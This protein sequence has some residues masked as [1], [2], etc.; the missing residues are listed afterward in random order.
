V[1]PYAY[2]IDRIRVVD[3]GKIQPHRTRPEFCLS[4]L[5][6]PLPIIEITLHVLRFP[7]PFFRFS[8]GSVPLC[9]RKKLKILLPS[10]LKL[11]GLI[12]AYLREAESTTCNLLISVIDSLLDATLCFIPL[13]FDL[14][15]T[16]R[17]PSSRP[18]LSSL[19]PLSTFG[20]NLD[21]RTIDAWQRWRK[22][23]ST[24]TR[25]M[26]SKTR[27]PRSHPHKMMTLNRITRARR[28]RRQHS[29]TTYGSSPIL[30]WVIESFWYV[31][32]L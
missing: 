9:S 22:H 32:F 7:L 16:P 20:A 8:F 10:E 1:L 14:Y 19:R 6:P 26:S 25:L 31:V 11:P 23:L 28:P 27:T 3:L 29:V 30:L 15:I 12:S 24:S 13:I 5:S 2:Q 18:F 21:G 17:L 4:C